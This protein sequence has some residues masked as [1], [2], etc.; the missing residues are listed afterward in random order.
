MRHH[1]Q[2]FARGGFGLAVLGASVLLLATAACDNR[3]EVGRPSFE[4]PTVPGPVVPGSGARITESRTIEGV[5]GVVLLA[6]GLVRI[7]LGAREALTISAPGDVMPLLTSEVV[8]GR[9]LLDRASSSYQGQA[10]DIR[11]DIDVR[12]LDEVALPGVGSMDAFGVD[13][14]RF[15][16]ELTGVGDISASGRADRQV[17]RVSGLGSYIAPNLW[18]RVAE[19]SITGGGK[20]VV[21]VSERLEGHVSFPCTLE[22]WGDPVVTVTGNGTVRRLGG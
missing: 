15:R 20:A 13:A 7:D 3:V 2:R 16:V 8:G 18:S 19:V 17:I 21:R 4:L 22:Y 12:R 9:L 1:H 11:Y 14:D 6:V 5:D 10:S